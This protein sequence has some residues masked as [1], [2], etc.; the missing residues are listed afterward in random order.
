GLL[1]FLELLKASVRNDEIQL[2]VLL[3][4]TDRDLDIR[5]R[6]RACNL[7]QSQ[8]ERLQFVG[9]NINPILL[10]AA[11]LHGHAS[12]AGNGRERRAQGVKREV[13][14]LDQRKRVGSENV[15]D[16]WEN[17]RIHPLDFERR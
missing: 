6:K 7:R 3:E 1:D 13:A 9:I 11:A 14:Q 16:A 12:D 4:M 17:G 2:V 10:D 8:F 5:G 15:G